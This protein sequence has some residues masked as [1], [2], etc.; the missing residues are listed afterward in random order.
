M[1]SFHHHALLRRSVD[2]L[3]PFIAS[4]LE[5]KKKKQAFQMESAGSSQ[6]GTMRGGLSHL[7]IARSPL[8]PHK[9]SQ[10]MFRAGRQRPAV[11]TIVPKIPKIGMKG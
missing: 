8:N 2:V 9:A 10:C 4:V 1:H 5:E 3:R 11:V 7:R 6:Y